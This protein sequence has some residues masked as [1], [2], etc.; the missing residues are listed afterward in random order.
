MGFIWN[1]AV[2]HTIKFSKVEKTVHGTRPLDVTSWLLQRRCIVISNRQVLFGTKCGR[3]LYRD[4]LL[5]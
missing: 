3:C 2:K 5:I 4:D 1:H